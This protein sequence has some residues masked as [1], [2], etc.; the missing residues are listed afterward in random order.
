MIREGDDV[1]AIAGVRAVVSDGPYAAIRADLE[2]A[3]V[4]DRAVDCDLFCI[5]PID[6][7]SI[8]SVVPRTR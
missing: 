8:E 2:A 7:I 4:A 5:L 3:A 6:I 1:G